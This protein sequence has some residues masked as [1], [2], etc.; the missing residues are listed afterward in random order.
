MDI[1]KSESAIVAVKRVM[2]VERRAGRQIEREKETMTV[3]SND[4]QPWLTKLERI[5][6]KSACDRS[7]VFNNLGHLIDHDML[8]EQFRRLGGNKAVGVDRVTKAEWGEELDENI[9]S[10]LHR[11]RKGIYTP[12]PAKITEI[13]KEDGSNRP[14]A[15]SCVEDKVVQLAVSTILNRIYEPLFLPCSYGFRPGLNCH[16]ALQDLQ[17]QTFR[18]WN[19]AV[20]EIDIR[21]YFNRI[22]HGKLMELL[23]KK[24]SDRRFLRLIEV[25]ITAPVLEKG[26]PL[27]NEIGCPQGSILSPVLANIYLHHVIDEWFAEISHSHI[28]GRADMVRYADDMVFTFEHLHEAKRFYSVLPK[29]LSRFGLELHEDKSQLIA[30]GHVAAMRANQRGERLRTFNFLGFT[31]YWGTTRKGYWRL[32]FTSRKDR[33]AVKLK[34][35][36]DFLWKNLSANRRQTLNTVIRVVR[37]WINYHGIS[38]N[39][40]RVGQFI[41]QSKRIIYRWFNRKGGHRPMTWGKLDLILKMLGYPSLWKT[42]SM[43]QSR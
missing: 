43:F 18:N 11:I 6:E 37:G 13:P 40:R 2:T 30:V 24:I 23:R 4:G 34:G 25:L 41:Y 5:G 15:V 27:S 20:V 16:M 8:K 42:R 29:R 33:F 19:G 22:P 1:R 7:M 3:L 10:L 35:L 9:G 28:R 14:L 12:L 17:Q 31:C 38:D 21:K 36:R 39:K 26:K 32:K